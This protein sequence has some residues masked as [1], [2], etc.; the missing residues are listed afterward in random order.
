MK[1]V[2]EWKFGG[3][4]E[5]VSP[6]I[7]WLLLGAA[8]L[9][10]LAIAYV[11][12][13]GTLR[14][15]P[16]RPR[17]MLFGLRGLFCTALILCLANPTR[18]ER[19]VLDEPGRKPLA[20]VIDRSES[21]TKKDN[22]GRSRLDVAL[23]TWEKIRPEAQERFEQFK[24]SSFAKEVAFTSSLEAA[25]TAKH[26]AGETRMFHSLDAVLA[27]APARG[28]HAILCVTDALET[29]PDR[30]SAMIT[31]AISSRTPLYF[32]PGENRLQ[33]HESMRVHS[34]TAPAQALRRTQFNYQAVIDAYV[35]HD[36]DL[37]VS[38]AAGDRRIA[39]EVLKLKKGRNVV[40][41]SKIVEATEPGTMRLEFRAGE[42]ARQKSAVNAV[43]VTESIGVNL[44][45][46][47]GALDWGFHFLKA[48]FQRDP[49]FRVTALFNPALGT[50]IRTGSSA[51]PAPSAVP[52]RSGLPNHPQE[53]A[54]YQLV[55]LD[56]VFAN[57][58]SA[59]QQ[60]A[61]IDYTRNGGGLLFILPNAEAAQAFAG[62]KLEEMLPVVFEPPGQESKLAE[63][64]DRFQRTMRGLGSGASAQEPGAVQTPLTPFAFPAQSR[65][66][67]VFTSQGGSAAEKIVPLFADYAA[68]RRAKPAAEVL[69]VHP[70]AKSPET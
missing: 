60:Q 55:V 44:L 7:G 34:A 9:A 58:L 23:R 32:L 48:I 61:L 31:K 20:I 49:S 66:S 70:T 19:L 8:L 24:F 35:G 2:T 42:G 43:R 17:W 4:L 39:A 59:L 36:Q 11:S 21:M 50:R 47:Q 16:R 62:S 5:G 57:Q 45:Y 52:G 56:H 46:Y 37:P 12:Y 28:Y 13:R 69:A 6:G 64:V 53:L 65:L 25:L 26:S 67:H 63:T 30:S 54:K 68:V 27:S 18:V 22:R 14:E 40:P 51:A 10:G 29:T 38:L 3:W 41:W 33:P 1:S 15:L